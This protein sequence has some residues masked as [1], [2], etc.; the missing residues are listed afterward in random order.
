VEQ[1]RETWWVRPG[2]AGLEKIFQSSLRGQDGSRQVEVN[3][4]GRELVVLREQLPRPG[5]NLIL[6]LDINLQLKAEELFAGKEGAI[7]AL[8]PRNG[9][10]LFWASLPAYDPNL[11]AVG[12]SSK[13]WREIINNPKDPLQNRAIQGQYPPGSVFKTVMA[14]AALEEGIVTSD[15]HLTCYG[16]FRLSPRSRK[17]YDCWKWR[18]HGSINIHE[19]LV[20][21]CNVFYYQ[22]GNKLGLEN[23]SKWA[24]NFRL[25]KPTGIE[26][27]N[28]KTG[29][30]PTNAW[31]LKAVGERWYPGETIS[32]SIGQGFLSVTPLQLASVINTIANGGIIYRPKLVDRIIS[33]QGDNIR[34]YPKEV[35]SRINARP[36]SFKIV[37]QGLHGVVNERG[38]A[39]RARIPGLGVSGKTGTAQVI[40]KRT[41]QEKKKKGEVPEKFKDHAWFVSFAPVEDPQIAMAILVEHGGQGG[42]ACA[43]IAK[44]M[45]AEYFKRYNPE[46]LLA[47]AEAAAAAAAIKKTTG[48]AKSAGVTSPGGD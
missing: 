16:F 37:R 30:V 10:V 33:P 22:V 4:K 17:I 21:S 20:H 32:I 45:I 46:R 13:R 31:K 25:G 48:A 8:D 35:L 11:F 26:L 19:S 42:R 14:L 44:Q 40:R 12:I 39:T 18:G 6:S 28:E 9:E 1:N 27:P 3:A 43:P 29:L 34:E 15:T 41:L 24:F 7:I 5:N 47:A 2:Q 38:T 36:K 23:I